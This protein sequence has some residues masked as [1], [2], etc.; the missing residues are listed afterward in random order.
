MRSVTAIHVT[1]VSCQ[2]RAIFIERDDSADCRCG[3]F[4]VGSGHRYPLLFRGG[5]AR[6]GPA[7]PGFVA[8]GWWLLAP[9]KPASPPHTPPL[10]RRAVQ[11]PLSSEPRRAE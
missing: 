5:A 9:P 3:S 10:T 11:S 7:T 4:G 6:L 1:S 2:N 8:A